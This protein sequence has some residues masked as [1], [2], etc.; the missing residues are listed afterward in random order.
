MS[1]DDGDGPVLADRGLQLIVA[2]AGRQAADA[3]GREAI[4]LNKG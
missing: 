3:L 2:Q 4:A 1:Q